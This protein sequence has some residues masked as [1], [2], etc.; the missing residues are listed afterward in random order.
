MELRKYSSTSLNSLVE[1]ITVMVL[2]LIMAKLQV[3]TDEAHPEKCVPQPALAK[4][5][6]KQA[7]L[8]KKFSHDGVQCVC[9]PMSENGYQTRVDVRLQVVVR[10]PSALFLQPFGIFFTLE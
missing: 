1:V 7:S 10:K 2:T 6:V 4:I 3:C 5:Q 9:T 8:S